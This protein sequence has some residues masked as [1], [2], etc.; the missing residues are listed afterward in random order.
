MTIT[1]R[2]RTWAQHWHHREFDASSLAAL[3]AGSRV[4]VVIPAR[5][6][7]ATIAAI[8]SCIRDRLMDRAVLVDELIVVDSHSRD[9]TARIAE[10]AGATVVHQTSGQ[11]SGDGGKGQA[12]RDGLDASTG[13]LIVF[14]DADIRDFDERFVVGLLGPLLAQPDLALVKATYRRPLV[15]DGTVH[16]DAGGRVTELMARPLLARYWPELADLGQPLAGEY[17]ASRSVLETVGLV[18]GFGVDLALLLDVAARFSPA[19]IGQVDMGQRTHA[20]KPIAA[21]VPM[22]EQIL[23]TAT[24]RLATLQTDSP[25]LEHASALLRR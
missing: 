6:E 10:Q 9:D 12:M 16:P 18:T 8:V 20:N 21:L 25:C 15:L 19:A 24:R 5:D 13:D 14:V 1:H 22:A 4:S 7:Q 11:N 17:A 23:S 3:A 2:R